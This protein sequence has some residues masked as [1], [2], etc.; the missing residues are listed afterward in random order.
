MR[1]ALIQ[2]LDTL[3]SIGVDHEEVY[4]TDVRERL[5]EAIER[6]LIAPS[7]SVDVPAKLGMF[8]DEADERVAAALHRYLTDARRWAAV[9]SNHKHLRGPCGRAADHRPFV[10]WLWFRALSGSGGGGPELSEG[11]VGAVGPGGLAGLVGGGVDIAV[12]RVQRLVAEQGLDLGGGRAV[13]GEAGGER[14]PQAARPADE[15]G[16]GG[17]VAP[18]CSPGSPG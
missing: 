10:T 8:S 9:P 5:G 4:D 14:M 7:G 17:G 18:A 2:F 13:F 6:N 11:L 3:E 16:L 12:R 1:E 15:E